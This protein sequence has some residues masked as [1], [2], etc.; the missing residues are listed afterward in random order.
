MSTLI[1]PIKRLQCAVGA[2]AAGDPAASVQ[3]IF[4]GPVEEGF[5]AVEP[6]EL[7]IVLGRLTAKNARKLDQESG[8]C[9]AIVGSDELH[10]AEELGVVVSAE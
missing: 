2:P 3:A 5:L 4:I 8:R 1:R 9:S 6:D 7:D 10:F